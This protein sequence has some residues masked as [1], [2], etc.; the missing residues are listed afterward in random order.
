[1]A[2]PTSTYGRLIAWT[3]IVFGLCLVLVAMTGSRSL[4]EGVDFGFRSG[5]AVVEIEGTILASETTVRVIESLASRNEVK[6]IL[7][8]IESPGGGVVS[9]DEIYRAVQRARQ[10]EEKPVVAYLGT[11][12]ASGGYYIACAADSIV[13]HPAST[14]GSIGVIVQYAVTEEMFRKLGIEWETLTTGPY[15]DMGSPFK[16][17]TE[18]HREWFQTVIE[19]DYE[20]FLDVIRAGRDLDEEQL[21]QYADGRIFTG[22]QAVAWGFADRVGDF[23]DAVAMAGEMGG[24]G[25]DPR[26]IRV[27]T[28]RNLTVWDFVFGRAGLVEL[29]R[30]FGLGP[31]D[32][33]HVYYLMR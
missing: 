18:R 20:Q 33:P 2:R 17:A 21:R 31:V 10:N 22:R 29:R 5:V 26:L 3:G 19:D 7:L 15:K 30:E 11:V 4:A 28:R 27:R 23:R 25:A 6:S 12:A 1:M 32:A 16:T 13:A 9:S 8:K 24:L 14:T